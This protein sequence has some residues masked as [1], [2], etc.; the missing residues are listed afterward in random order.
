MQHRLSYCVQGY[1]DRI[2]TDANL[3]EKVASEVEERTCAQ[4]AC[5]KSAASSE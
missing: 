3:R 4:L 5:A 2:A 1:A